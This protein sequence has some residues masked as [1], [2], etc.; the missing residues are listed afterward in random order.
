M[1][2]RR[3]SPECLES[4]LEIGLCTRFA[5]WSLGLGLLRCYFLQTL[6][7]VQD[8]VFEKSVQFSFFVILFCKFLNRINTVYLI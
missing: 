3:E 2:L 5:K 8:Q 4:S 1:I 7:L 6:F